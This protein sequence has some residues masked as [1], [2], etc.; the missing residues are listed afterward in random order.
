ML[1]SIWK[2]LPMVAAGVYEVKNEIA[3]RIGYFKLG[4]NLNTESSTAEQIRRSMKEVMQ[5]RT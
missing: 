4:G 3:A 1:M 5:N 2:G